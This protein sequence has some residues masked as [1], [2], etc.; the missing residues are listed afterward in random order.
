[1]QKLV[2]I[3]LKADFGFFRKPDSNAGINLSYNMLHKPSLMGILGA[4]IGLGGYKEFGKVPEYLEKLKGIK[5][6]ICPLHHDKGSFAKAIIQYSDTTGY[7]NTDKDKKPSTRL[8]KESAL[9]APAYRCFLLLQMEN[10]FH[11]KLYHYLSEGKA[12]YLPYFGKNEFAAWWDKESFKGDYEVLELPIEEDVKIIT[13]ICLDDR[14]EESVKTAFA[15]AVTNAR[16][17]SKEVSF[18]YFERLPSEIIASD[19]AFEK[20]KNVR[21]NY[22]P[23]KKFVYS[24]IIFDKEN[25]LNIPL[26]RI[27][28]GKAIQVF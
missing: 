10:E 3:D 17:R 14:Q 27:E 23:L 20:D 16:T 15:K 7:N 1:M 11:S 9:I 6:G 28:P 12:E 25:K 8:M 19:A 21:Y 5:V 22:S 24:N 4:I 13:L 2:S 26:I 18:L